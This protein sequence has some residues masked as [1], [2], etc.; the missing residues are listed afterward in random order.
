MIHMKNKVDVAIIGAG[1][2][3]SI[4]A[5]ALAKSGLRVA[6]IDSTHHPRFAIGESSTP[7]ADM[8]LRRLAKIY[9]LPFLENLST[10]GS[11]QH[12]F[13]QLACGRKR[14]FSY[15]RHH[16][17]QF[18]SEQKL[19]ENSLLVAASENNEVADTHWYR[20]EVDEFLFREAINHG[21]IEFLG[22]KIVQI[23]NETSGS[24]TLR[25]IAESGEATVHSDW[26]VDASGSAAVSAKIM[27]QPDLTN[28]LRTQTRTTYGHY[29]DVGSWSQQLDELGQNTQQDPFDSDD[30]AQHHLLDNG[31][32]WMLRF[33][34]G[35][36]SVGRT[37]WIGTELLDSEKLE[38]RQRKASQLGNRAESLSHNLQDYPS[39]DKI[40]AMASLTAPPQGAR[41]N[42]RL[43]RLVPPLISQRHLMLPTAAMTLDPLHSTGIA[44][45]LA[46]VDRILNVI[47]LS[48]DNKNQLHAIKQYESSFLEESDLLDELVS[49]AYQV[50][51]DFERFTAACMI[52]FAGAICCEESYQQGYHP[53]HLWNADDTEFVRFAKQAC[54]VLRQPNDEY[55]SMI[56]QGLSPWNTAGLMDPGVQNRYAYTATK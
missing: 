45:A 21:A 47:L 4:L 6:L 9:Q 56:T 12:Q 30:A 49:T 24:F 44:H 32:L 52:Y 48:G 26:I 5:T 53:T 2:A 13:P 27:G 11:W 54:L 40:M 3:G 36:T 39:L 33:N 16:R 8:I 50:M 35:I 10:W 17:H 34:N 7:L 46:G 42:A 22:H 28:T 19:G 14:G 37:E 1:F 38:T 51:G 23:E 43:Q 25:S 20:E 41:S 55:K 31:W 29:R 18:Y 15:Y